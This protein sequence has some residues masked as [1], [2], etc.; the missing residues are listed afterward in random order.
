MSDALNRRQFLNRSG[1]GLI[2]LAGASVAG[3][4]NAKTQDK[5][6]VVVITDDRSLDDK[7]NIQDQV[8]QSMIDSGIRET[9]GIENIGEAWKSIFPEI[10][11]EKVI[12][13]KVNCLFA[14]S[15]HPEVTFAVINGLTQMVFDDG[16]FPEENI[17]IF[18]RATSHLRDNG[19]YTIN[20]SDK[21]VKCYSNNKGGYTSQTYKVGGVNSKLS[22]ILTDESDY[23]INICVMK[24]H[25]I[26]GVT[27]SLKN[28]Y[29]TCNNPGSLH[30]G[31]CDPYLPELNA[32]PDIKDKQV[33]N[34]CDALFAVVSGGPGGNP[35]KTPKQILMSK[36]TVALDTVGTTILREQGMSKWSETIAT[37]VATAAAAPYSL[38]TNDPDQIERVDILNPSMGVDRPESTDKQPE[39][40]HIYPNYPNPFN[41]ETTLSVKMMTGAQLNIRIF[42]VKGK[43]VNTLINE[44]RPAGY[45]RIRWNGTNDHGESLA[46]GTYL[47]N[48]Q[49]GNH[50]QS[51]RMQLV[52]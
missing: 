20:E 10:S 11:R 46:S 33:L 18:D 37:H 14:L 51:L 50:Q 5:S 19:K 6:K 15:T 31:H 8:V 21:G 38:G 27:L 40:Y 44:H 4:T 26:A 34:I 17:I 9:T 52:K 2:G 47:A 22:K 24:N 48:I 25:S 36:D 43:L 12:C 32:L 30:G 35:Q 28:H 7:Y 41:A 42:D 3:T 1:S 39:D 16:N 13:I 45:Y 49:L 29:G 23:M